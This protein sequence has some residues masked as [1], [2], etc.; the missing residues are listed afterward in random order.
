MKRTIQLSGKE[1]CN[2][3]SACSVIQELEHMYDGFDKYKMDRLGEAYD[4]LAELL[5]DNKGE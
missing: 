3:E 1:F 4:I 2:V 5:E